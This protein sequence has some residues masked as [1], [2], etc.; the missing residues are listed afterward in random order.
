MAILYSESYYKT[1]SVYYDD[2]I[3]EMF[4]YYT[5]QRERVLFTGH[6][7]VLSAYNGEQSLP[8]ALGIALWF[9]KCE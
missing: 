8:L 4:E 5:L 2:F 1:E 6:T 7:H 9:H 3:S